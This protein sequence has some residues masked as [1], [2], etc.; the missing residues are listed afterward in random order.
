MVPTHTQGPARF[1]GD[2]LRH[3][4]PQ[5]GIV[6]AMPGAQVGAAETGAAHGQSRATRGDD[7]IR[8]GVSV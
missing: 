4:A 7:L 6:V 5:R 8:C 3:Q 2:H 1:T